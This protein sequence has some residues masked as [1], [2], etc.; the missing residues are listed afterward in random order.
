MVLDTA[1]AA[2][3]ACTVQVTLLNNN[4]LVAITAGGLPKRYIL[5][6]FHFHWGTVDTVGSEHTVDGHA[7][8]MEVTKSY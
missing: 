4:D 7:Y 2:V 8:P 6:Q 5:E 1:A 3:V